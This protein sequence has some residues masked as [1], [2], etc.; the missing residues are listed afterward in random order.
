MLSIAENRGD[1]LPTE[2]VGVV[3]YILTT[4][5]GRKFTTSYF[6]EKTGLRHHSAWEMLCKLSRVLPIV[7]DIDGW[8]MK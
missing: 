8:Y 7:Q 2:R 4:N 3:V 1:T 6:A 5:R